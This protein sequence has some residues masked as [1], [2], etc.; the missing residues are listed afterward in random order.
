[1]TAIQLEGGELLEV[2]F[3]RII[4][5]SK[6]ETEQPDVNS[7]ENEDTKKLAN[8]LKLKSSSSSNNNII[9]SLAAISTQ[10]LL[11]FREKLKLNYLSALNYLPVL[12]CC[13]LSQLL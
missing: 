12:C 1:M 7:E 3:I 5:C 13:C 6:D 9:I 11:H 10:G 2:C 4:R 8:G